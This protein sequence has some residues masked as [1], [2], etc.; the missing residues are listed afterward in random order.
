MLKILLIC[1]DIP[2]KTVGSTLPIYHLIKELGKKYE[3]NLV[4]FDSKKYSIS[5]LEDYLNEHH[6]ITIPEYLDFA[7]QFKYTV[8]NMLS[9]DNLN[10]KSFLNYYYHKDMSKLISE[11]TED[12]DLVITDMP[13][14]FYAKKIQIPKIVYAF[15]AVSKYNYDMF[16]K[17]GNITSKAYWYLNYLKTREYEKVYDSF[18]YCVLVNNKDKQLLKK[19]INTPIEVIANGV[20]TK[21]FTNNSMEDEVRLVFLGDMSTPPNNDAVKY[22]MENIYP[23]VLKEISVNF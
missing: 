14:A 15:D 6:S 9:Y 5:E 10:T 3:I 1:H 13:M 2:S 11:T 18:D 8:K 21:Y 22:F 17:S 23:E 7:N 4:S 16:K 20:D 12:I 19:N